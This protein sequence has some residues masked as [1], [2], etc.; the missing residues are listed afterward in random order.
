MERQNYQ[1][2]AVR[3]LEIVEVLN[4]YARQRDALEQCR[5]LLHVAQRYV[6]LVNVGLHPEL[7]GECNGERPCV[8]CRALAATRL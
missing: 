7:D 1:S 5:E 4:Q 6:A 8:A 3:T 2:P